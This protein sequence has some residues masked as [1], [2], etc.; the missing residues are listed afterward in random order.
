MLGTFEYAVIGIIGFLAF[1]V[2][3]IA[4]LSEE[5]QT[6]TFKYDK[7]YADLI[8]RRSS[9]S[10]GLAV[11]NIP[12]RTCFSI[13]DI[14]F[15]QLPYDLRSAILEAQKVDSSSD[16]IVYDGVSFNTD[17]SESL[18]LI[19][20][21]KFNQSTREYFGIQRISDTTYRFECFF[22]YH[23]N[24]YK[25]T[26]EFGGH[27]YDSNIVNVN[28]TRNDKGLPVIQ[29]QNVT[30]YYGGF[31]NT[32]LFHNN[33]DKEIILLENTWNLDPSEI[34]HHDNS[35]LKYTIPPG[36]FASH[37]FT[38]MA[39]DDIIRNY[40]VQPYNLQG[41]VIVKHYPRCMTENEVKSLYA[42]VGAYPKFPSYVPEGY[43]FECGIHV[44]N[45]A[46]VLS[47]WTDELR[48]KFEDDITSDMD[49]IASG[50]ITIDYYNNFV[51][52]Y[53]IKNPDYDKYEQAKN[54]E[55]PFATTLSV[56]GNPAVM[57]K[58]YFWD[59]GEQ[60]SF[61][62]LMIFSDNEIWY[63]IRS[64]LPAGEVIKIAESLFES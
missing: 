20:K 11:E 54:Y 37:Y 10:V 50:G 59:S 14:D 12:N 4:L 28:F 56:G 45:A 46:V 19:S 60:K 24:Q 47:Y 58:E 34:L 64:G 48:Q 18:G 44:F 62:Q 5:S 13:N 55:N 51:L 35:P 40:E 43:S 41:K 25:L 61:N 2:V 6:E 26:I 30:V 36:K 27:F 17:S 15:S 32:V 7:D 23:E 39:S 49:F 38:S 42:Q 63:R 22:E 52:N 9:M 21:Y 31:N 57:I 29:N 33:L 3:A 8:P 16:S 53:W 1:S